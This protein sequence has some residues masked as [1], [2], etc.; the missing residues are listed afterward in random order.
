MHSN[1]NCTREVQ[2]TNVLCIYTI[3]CIFSSVNSLDQNKQIW[4]TVLCTS[5][6]IKYYVTYIY[7]SIWPEL[8]ALFYD[9]NHNL[10]HT[11]SKLNR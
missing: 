9:F 5:N 11:S 8:Q 4:K 3:R 7:K 10:F 1:K 6:I 2:L